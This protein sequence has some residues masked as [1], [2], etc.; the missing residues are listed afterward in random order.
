[1]RLREL[2]RGRRDQPKPSGWMDGWIDKWMNSSIFAHSIFDGTWGRS[3][4]A[5]GTTVS[6]ACTD[7]LKGNGASGAAG[8]AGPG[9]GLDLAMGVAALVI[10]PKRIRGNFYSLFRG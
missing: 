2:P 4:T 7:G 5:L 10:P 3:G 8:A 6:P 9:P 1:M